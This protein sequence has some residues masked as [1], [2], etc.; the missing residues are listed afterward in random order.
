[1]ATVEEPVVVAKVA[2]AEPEAAAKG[3]QGPPRERED[4]SEVPID[5]SLLIRV[6][7]AGVGAVAG[8]AAG[9]AALRQVSRPAWPRGH[10]V[11]RTAARARRGLLRL[12][13]A[14]TPPAPQLQPATNISVAG[15]PACG[16]G[17]CR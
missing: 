3:E 12:A 8:A 17:C 14:A 7:G 10:V 6:R 11:L 15:G 9:G 1:M 2:E 16:S 4:L 13:R 5:E